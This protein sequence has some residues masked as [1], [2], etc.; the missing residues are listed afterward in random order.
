MII[1]AHRQSVVR[2]TPDADGHA[3][4]LVQADDVMRHEKSCLRQVE[5][6]HGRGAPMTVGRVR[7]ACLAAAAETMGATG[8]T[9]PVPLGTVEFCRSWMAVC[10]ITEPPHMSYPEDLRDLLGRPV[11]PGVWSDVA[12]GEFAKPRHRIKAWTG[13]LRGAPDPDEAAVIAALDPAEPVWRS[14]AIIFRS[15]L[16][17]YVHRGRSVGAARY[18]D[19]PDDAPTPDS[20]A[21][22]A[23]VRRFGDRVAGAAMD[24]GVTDAGETVLVEVNDG[25]ALGYYPWGD[26]PAA[27]YL[28]L[29]ADRWAEIAGD[30]RNDRGLAAAVTDEHS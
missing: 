24:F 20:T 18:D 26:C 21:V 12:I 10:D 23:A 6:R 5:F 14:P 19:G 22:A 7:L 13:H 16:R 3:G 8:P 28:A 4:F 25:W 29:I 9:P 2:S 15:E 17:V 27:A 1:Q 30:G 11:A